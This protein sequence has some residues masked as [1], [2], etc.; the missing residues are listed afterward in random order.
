MGEPGGLSWFRKY[1]DS[2]LA[3]NAGWM[4]AGQGTGLLFQV[5]Y[6]ILL[7][8]LLGSTEY[9]VYAGAYAFTTLVAQCSSLGMGTVFL[10][11][12]S[13]NPDRFAP[14]WGNILVATIG[15]S[16]L[17]MVILPVVGRHILNPAS[18]R[19]VLVA[20]ISNCLCA[21]LTTECGRTFQ[22]AEK[23]HVAAMLNLL[24]YS[25]RFL[26]VAV[27]FVAL[28]RATAWQWAVASMVGSA[29]VAGIAVIA[30]LVKFGPP[31]FQ[32]D[33]FRRHAWE[34]LGFSF[35][36]STASAYNDLDKTMLS[37]YG[38]NQANGIYTLAY[39][40][41]D[42]ATMPTIAVRDAALPKLFQRGRLGLYHASELAERLLK[43]TLVLGVVLSVCLYL[44]A[45]L[46]PHL[47]SR[48]F[49]ESVIALR[50]L[51]LL[52][53]F[54]V[55]HQMSGAALTS[56]GFQRYRT[57][58]QLFAVA[59]NFGLNLWLIPHYGWRGAAWSSLASDCLLGL[60]NWSLL[61]FL[62]AHDRLQKAQPA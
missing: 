62:L 51:A 53:I 28:H 13:G 1:R 8:H 15:T 50:W 4:M 47:A 7:A 19:L 18:A 41:V 20:A 27:M 40:V 35:A 58:A 55:V 31:S 57:G 39:R 12:V 17:L 60:A 29:M 52:P 16:G 11:Y 33:V 24:T 56:A 59:L 48:G 5:G 43:R 46:I 25:T 2:T 32:P 36:G 34:G 14:Y 21:Q 45:P 49:G 37:H 61:K 42:L 44:A 9:G 3:R 26:I 54:R 6:F 23:M 38:M 30:V 10:R 22:S